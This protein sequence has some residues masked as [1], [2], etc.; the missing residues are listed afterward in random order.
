MK[1]FL[2]LCLVGAVGVVG[3]VS[4]FAMAVASGTDSVEFMGERV[5]TVDYKYSSPTSFRF[6]D[7]ATAS[8]MDAHNGPAESGQTQ[9][10]AGGRVI[11]FAEVL[12][13]AAG[14]SIHIWITEQGQTEELAQQ[15]LQIPS[16]LDGN[17]AWTHISFTKMQAGKYTCHFAHEQQIR[18]VSFE[19]VAPRQAQASR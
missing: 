5:A 10:E 3:C 4:L 19:V 14:D 2:M 13:P 7:V 1:T 12:H 11:C 8:R 17:R 16:E 15:V 18:E 6:R 9:F